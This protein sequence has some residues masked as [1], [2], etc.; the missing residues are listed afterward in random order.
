M[1]NSELFTRGF[2]RVL[3]SDAAA[4]HELLEQNRAP[5]GGGEGGGG[6]RGERNF[7]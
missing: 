1:R 3:C 4:N 7:V 2:T 5:Y 6:G